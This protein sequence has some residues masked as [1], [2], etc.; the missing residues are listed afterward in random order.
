MSSTRSTSGPSSTR[1]SSGAASAGSLPASA[2]NAKAGKRRSSHWSKKGRKQRRANHGFDAMIV[3]PVDDGEEDD[4]EADD[5]D[6][7]DDVD[8]AGPEIKDPMDGADADGHGE[9]GQDDDEDEDAS[10]EEDD[11]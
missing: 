4:D 10:E 1:N 2:T 6:S 7:T 9:S 11:Q 8:E 3:A 5:E